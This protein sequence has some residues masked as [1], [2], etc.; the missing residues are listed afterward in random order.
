MYSGNMVVFGQSGCIPD[1]GCIG[2]KK[3]YSSKVVIFGQN[4]LYSGKLLEFG[5]NWL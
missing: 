4:L 5:Q 1:S 3:L 2:A